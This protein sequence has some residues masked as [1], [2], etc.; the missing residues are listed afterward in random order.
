MR[1]FLLLVAFGLTSSAL[2]QQRAPLSP[3]G[4]KIQ[5]A[6]QSDIRS[7]QELGRDRNRKPI[8][9][10]EFLGLKDDMTVVE[11]LPGGGWYSKLLGPVLADKGQLYLAIGASRVDLSHKSMSK[12]ELL[13]VDAQLTP[14]EGFGVFNVNEFSL[15]VEDVDMVLTFRN[16]H[17]LTAESRGRMNKAVYD[18]LAPGG[19]YG[20]IDHTR[21]HME[22]QNAENVRRADP[23]QIIKEALDAGFEFAAFSD[24]HF[25]ADDELRYEVG[26]RSVA[27]NSD[28]FTLKFVKPK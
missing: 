12:I 13:E 17:N 25:R 1:F 24:L 26:R 11:L 14:A 10:L 7:A 20:V 27:G 15:P 5:A 23:V 3:L 28:R 18:A 2:A 21:R 6:M 22:K 9:T 4:E 19:I 8:Q 16:M